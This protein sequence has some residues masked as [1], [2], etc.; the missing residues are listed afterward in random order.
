MIS[1]LRTVSNFFKRAIYGAAKVNRLNVG[2]GTS[3]RGTQNGNLRMDSR[4]LKARC[5]E[6]YRDMP[7]PRSIINAL[8]SKTIAAPIVPRSAMQG[9]SGAAA[10]WR[11]NVDRIFR[12]WADDKE[13]FS[14]DG[15]M[16]MVEMQ[17][18]IVRGVAV[19][20]EIFVV[21][22][23][24]DNGPG[25]PPLRLELVESVFLD[26]GILQ[27]GFA[28]ID[29]KGR[30]GIEVDDDGRPL[31]YHFRRPNGQD[32][33]VV[34]ANRVLHIKI[35]LYA[36]QYVGEPLLAAI[37]QQVYHFENFQSAT[38]QNAENCAKIFMVATTQD[39]GGVGDLL[40][41]PDA[42]EATATEREEQREV[43]FGQFMNL[44][45]GESVTQMDMK[46]PGAQYGVFVEKMI[47]MM[48]AVAGLPYEVVSGDFSG[49]NYSTSRM[50]DMVA[51][52]A[53]LPWREMLRD[54]FCCPIFKAFMVA[55]I[56][57]GLITL[58]GERVPVSDYTRC[59]VTMPGRRYVDPEKEVKADAEAMKIGSK[60]WSQ[61]QAERGNDPEEQ[62]DRIIKDREMFKAAGLVYPG[63]LDTMAKAAASIQEEPAAE[64]E[65]TEEGVAV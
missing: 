22:H 48:A 37:A 20:G 63:D 51:E 38:V 27:T 14:L 58:R 50:A 33:R 53:V 30:E 7:I 19:D 13:K 29:A 55:S 25:A 49:V 1:I 36:G 3:I 23:D 45:P 52:S 59:N 8:V 41:S 15:M 42:D 2:W 56:Q 47:K 57:G 31:R 16:S 5:Q 9:R 60:T 46:H 28:G 12:D 24:R 54:D 62:M 40:K 34:P 4:A 61:I 32:V 64:Q 35:D 10:S 26:S 11:K 21:M 43:A 17:R 65:P 6:L 18:A 44:M 39:G